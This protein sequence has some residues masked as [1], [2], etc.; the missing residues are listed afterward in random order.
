MRCYPDGVPGRFSVVSAGFRGS[1]SGCPVNDRFPDTCDLECFRL[2]LN[3]PRIWWV[4]AQMRPFR[5]RTCWREVL[6]ILRD[7]GPQ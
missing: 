1:E 4:S 7:A 3:V 5:I 2:L 6:L